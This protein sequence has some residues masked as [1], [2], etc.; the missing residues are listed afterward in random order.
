MIATPQATAQL[1]SVEDKP[2]QQLS[3]PEAV[4]RW[5]LEQE[6]GGRRIAL[7]PTMGYLHE[8]HL[9][10][11]RIARERAD[12]VL[13]SIFV[14]PT[15]FGP[16]EDLDRYPRDMRGDLK[17]L[18]DLGVHAAW[19]P[20]PEQIYPQGFST[21]VDPGPLA[22]TLCGRS[23]PGHF[24]GVCTVVAILMHRSRC[25]LAVFGE[26]DFQQLQIIRRMVHDLGLGVDIVGA[27]IVRDEQGLAL[28]S[29]NSYLSAEERERAVALPIALKSIE[30]AAEEGERE[31]E[32]LLKIGRA[33]LRRAGLKID[34][35][36]IVDP[37][38]LRPLC[39][40]DGPA[41]ALG[42]VHCG[43]TRLIDNRALLRVPI[44]HAQP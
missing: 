23:R 35:L 21:Y 6:R 14:N 30:Q 9:S 29:R 17:K 25:A 22:D 20:S 4:H 42:A 8:G 43:D 27:P 44:G 19:T 13:V 32:R 31:T 24:R 10:L 5:V 7:V 3:T 28:S 39:R 40:L 1:R 37:P 26:K 16:G 12:R 41:R 15:Q 18:H 34:Y 38:S 11:I 33:R 36:E 2:L